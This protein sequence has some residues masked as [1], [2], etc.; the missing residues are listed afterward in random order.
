VTTTGT[1]KTA[2]ERRE[3]IL[4]AA[5][6]EFACRGLHGAST[7]LI[8]RKAGI[9][10]PYLFRLFG[11]KKGL[12]IAVVEKC[13]DDTYELFRDAARGMRGEEALHAMGEAYQAMLEHHP[14]RLRVQMQGYA[15]CDDP[16][17]RRTM[18]GGFGRLTELVENVTG[19]PADEIARFFA[20]GMLLNTI[21]MLNLADDPTGWSL[22][23]VAGL[24]K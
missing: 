10:Q 5:F 2:G 18:R 17:I 13:L 9:S 11:T 1:R 14:M 22:S 12:F 16:D 8:S 20:T 15:A 3:Q 6:D 24:H 23:L 21:T 7:E 4:A 19:R